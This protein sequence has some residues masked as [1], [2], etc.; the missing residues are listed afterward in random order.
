[1]LALDSIFLLKM[2]KIMAKSIA[3]I[4]SNFTDF[5]K[6]YQD[7]LKLQGKTEYDPRQSA[8]ETFLN[9]Q[10]MPLRRTARRTRPIR[11]RSA[12]RTKRTNWTRWPGNWRNR[13]TRKR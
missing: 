10:L 13:P 12:R 9:H 2:N 4:T 1:M 3:D 11:T 7:Y 5:F 8:L 6:H